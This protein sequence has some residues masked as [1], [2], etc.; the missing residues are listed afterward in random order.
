MKDSNG[1]RMNKRIYNK[2]DDATV[3]LVVESDYDDV[4][5]HCAHRSEK[6]AE[7]CIRRRVNDKDEGH[8]HLGIQPIAYRR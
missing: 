6:N 2:R 4:M 3:Y 1:R 5:I 8:E 7:R